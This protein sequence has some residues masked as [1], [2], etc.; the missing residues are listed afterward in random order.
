MAFSPILQAFGYCWH[1]RTSVFLSNN[2]SIEGMVRRKFLK[3]IGLTLIK[4]QV[5]KRSSMT[6]LPRSLRKSVKKFVP[7]ETLQ[8]EQPPP[9]SRQR[10]MICP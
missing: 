5:V 6:S 9:H 4:S 3:E 7:V 2:R 8:V 1:K 10:C